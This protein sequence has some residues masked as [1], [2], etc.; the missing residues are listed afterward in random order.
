[1]LG[2]LLVDKPKGITSHDVIDRV[3][4]S[5]DT[6]KVGHAG[7]LDPMAT[8]LLVVAVG[9][10]T[11]FLQYLS[12]E[13]KIYEGEIT[14]GVSTT[15]QDADGEI[16]SQCDA[17]SLT[18]SAIEEALLSLVGEIEQ[19]PPMHS[20][21]Q[22]EGRRLYEMARK[23]E[24]IERKPRKVRVQEFC[25]SLERANKANFRVVCS[26]GTYIR[27]L[28]AD[29]G[30]ALGVGAHLSALRRIAAGAFTVEDAVSLGDIS[31]SH[32]IPLERALLPMPIL[33]IEE[34]DVERARHGKLLSFSAGS[35]SIVGLLGLE[36]FVGIARRTAEGL[37]HPECIIAN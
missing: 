22:I 14:F 35:E 36:G 3:R 28:A 5:F 4:K 6:K 15:T 9:S 33:A 24:T 10:A 30:D 31:E 20:A 21:V 25:V 32:L 12:L 8:G 11:R 27:T 29:L 37:W 26:G 34:T 23:G 17:C 7:T 16:V 13:P 19:V 18:Q 2:I 1:M